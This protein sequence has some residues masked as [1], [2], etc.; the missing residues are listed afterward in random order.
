VSNDCSLEAYVT[1]NT[2][3]TGSD[4]DV[5]GGDT[6]LTSPYFNLNTYSNPFIYYSRWFYNASGTTPN[7]TLKISIDNGITSKV[8]EVVSPSSSGNGTWVSK[9]FKVSNYLAKT[10]N[11]RIMV[12]TEDLAPNNIVE[13]GFDKF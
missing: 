8:L 11:M 5:D 7:D 12:R 1:G 4:D 9:S 3:T 13:A 6:K 2:G 10:A